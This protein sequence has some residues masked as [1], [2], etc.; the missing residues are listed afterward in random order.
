MAEAVGLN[1]HHVD[2]KQ[3]RGLYPG[4]DAVITMR[5]RAKPLGGFL[6]EVVRMKTDLCLLS[7]LFVLGALSADPSNAAEPQTQQAATTAIIGA[8]PGD[9]SRVSR[10]LASA[11][12]DELDLDFVASA[13]SKSPPPDIAAAMASWSI[14]TR[15]VTGK[16]S[17]YGDFFGLLNQLADIDN[18]QSRALLSLAY[19]WRMNALTEAMTK[20]WAATVAKL[21]GEK[22]QS[23]NSA[24][25]SIVQS[26]FLFQGS[27]E[28]VEMALTAG[29]DDLKALEKHRWKPPEGRWEAY[30]K[31]LRAIPPPAVLKASKTLSFSPSKAAAHLA[32]VNGLYRDGEFQS[33]LFDAAL[34][35]ALTA[36][37]EFKRVSNQPDRSAKS[38]KSEP[39]PKQP[40]SWPK[41]I[42]A[43]VGQNEVRV[44]N[45]NSFTVTIGLRSRGLGRDFIVPPGGVG[46][47]YVSEGRFEVYFLYSNEPD[48]VY[49]GDDL[50]LAQNGIE[51]KIVSRVDGNYGIRK[52]K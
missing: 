32:E 29:P 15:N 52:V 41:F 17:T 42:G 20:E 45:P 10:E 12:G 34:P 2:A 26:A 44:T 50:T 6:W 39:L 14:A 16:G 21:S 8:A 38:S 48:A 30:L 7:L 35:G 1:F 46:S 22:E 49:R 47:A 3:A 19:V 18:P 24:V 43:S 5:W 13:V 31:R 4:A 27:P 11:F 40:D 28:N 33:A 51:I 36:R 37:K 23:L 25:T 9:S